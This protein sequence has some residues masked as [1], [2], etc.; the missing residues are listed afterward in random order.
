MLGRYPVQYLEID[1]LDESLCIDTLQQSPPA[2]RVI[3]EIGVRFY[4]QGR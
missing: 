2:N 1:T 3:R 4:L